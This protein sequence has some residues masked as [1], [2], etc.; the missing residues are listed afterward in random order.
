MGL[1]SKL[2]IFARTDDPGAMVTVEELKAMMDRHED[3]TIVDVRNTARFGCEHIAGS[4]NIPLKLIRKYDDVLIGVLDHG[5]KL[6]VCCEDGDQCWAARD[7]LMSRGAKV[8]VCL[9]GGMKE[10]V[11]SGGMLISD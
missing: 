8:V 11:S 6:V 2:N 4:V 3:I 1:L 9:K 10:W 5:N 7:I